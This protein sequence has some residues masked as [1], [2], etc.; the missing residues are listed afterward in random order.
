[1][2]GIFGAEGSTQFETLY[3]INKE[4]GTFSFGSITITSS[5]AYLIC[6]HEGM[7]NFNEHYMPYDTKYIAGHTQAPTSCER[8]FNTRTT[9]PFEE[10]DWT[11]AHNGILSNFKELK[12]KF[13]P[14]HT[15]SVDSSIIP[16]L[17][18]EF[19]NE[20]NSANHI[21][22]IS[23]VLNTLKGTFAVWILNTATCKLY[24]AR[25]GSTLFFNKDMTCFSSLQCKGWESCD[26]G[27]IYEY[28]IE[29]FTEVG[30]FEADHPFFIV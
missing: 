20:D 15:N 30:S 13:V 16:A 24:L 2:C 12:S 3:D 14:W 29:G 17:L 23:R 8:E 5:E 19:E 10:G 1:M 25:S 6:K 4:R 27:C 21:S 28:T 11:V 26:E 9:H 22:L 7:I 18:N